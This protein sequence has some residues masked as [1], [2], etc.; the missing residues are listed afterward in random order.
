MVQTVNMLMSNYCLWRFPQI[1]RKLNVIYDVQYRVHHY[2]RSWIVNVHICSQR[3]FWKRFTRC[4]LENG[5]AENAKLSKSHGWYRTICIIRS[6][7]VELPKLFMVL[8]SLQCPFGIA[9]D[10]SS[11]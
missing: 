9:G 3:W 8:E 4:E 5:K 11:P 10:C 2:D 6:T 7:K 1:M